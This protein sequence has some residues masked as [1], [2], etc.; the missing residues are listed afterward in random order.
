MKRIQMLFGVLCI[1]IVLLG[2]TTPI[3]TVEVL[4]PAPVTEETPEP[5]VVEPELVVVQ[6][7]KRYLKAPPVKRYGPVVGVLNSTGYDLT[8]FDLFSDAMYLGQDRQ[9]NVLDEELEDGKQALI[10]L[11]Q[12]PELEAALSARDGSLFTFNAY[13]WEGD[14]YYGS[15]DPGKENWNIEITLDNLQERTYANL[16]PSFGDFLVVLNHTGYPLQALYLE[17]KHFL[18]LDGSETNL[19]EGT[20]LDTLMQVRISTDALAYALDFN[21]Y[22]TLYL[23]AI[24][25]DGDRYQ[26]LWYPTTDPWAI[27]LTAADLDFPDDA[28]FWLTASNGTEQTFWY[29]HAVSDEMYQAG[30]LG[31][32]LL[33]LD[34]L[35]GGEEI[36]V[37]LASLEY[38]H[39]EL[40][41]VGEG[42]IHL[43]AI[44][45][46]GVQYHTTLI[47]YAG[48]LSVHFEESDR[49]KEGEQGP[50]V[51]L[52][53]ETL[54]DLWFLYLAT[55]EMAAEQDWGRDLLGD[56][57]WEVGDPFSF[58]LSLVQDEEELHLYAYDVDDQLYHK[59]WHRF[60]DG[61]ELTFTVED[62]VDQSVV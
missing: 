22:A 48:S 53:N 57:I 35:D 16:V 52:Y 8:S 7:P 26:T 61:L 43:V 3:R 45:N 59:Q 50:F 56:E 30:D 1:L 47:P 36:D 17:E 19:L 2:C 24:D 46:D 54:S 51:T 32:D 13:D 62:L 28:S 20:V 39:D 21:S 9:V 60:S 29:L 44:T 41:G 4:P 49:D 31:N 14:F 15:W 25:T 12:Y 37:D 27:E 33:G 40:G 11:A 10:P 38:L 42:L 34:L 23:T 55:D 6:M 18:Q 58:S 5:L